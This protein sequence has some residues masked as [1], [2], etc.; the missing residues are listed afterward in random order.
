M[1]AKLHLGVR[2]CTSTQ[3]L[4][5]G[6]LLLALRMYSDLILLSGMKEGMRESLYIG[7]LFLIEAVNGFG[8]IYI[9][10]IVLHLVLPKEG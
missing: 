5:T 4:P 8:K 3:F 10:E 2:I 9:K 1:D 7:E 6:P